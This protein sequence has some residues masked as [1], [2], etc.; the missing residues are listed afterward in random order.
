MAPPLML[1]KLGA[2]MW[3][4]TPGSTLMVPALD[5][6]AEPA[7]LPTVNLWSLSSSVAPLMTP[8][9]ATPW[10]S[11]CATTGALGLVGTEISTVAPESVLPIGVDGTGDQ[12]AD[13]RVSQSPPNL[14]IQLNTLTGILKS[15][16]AKF[17]G[18]TA[19]LPASSV[20]VPLS[21]LKPT[22]FRSVVLSVSTV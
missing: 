14:L 4:S 22:T 13:V 15:A 21:K 16:A 10:S 5:D 17:A 6:V 11:V 1:L 3:N 18:S 12:L 2:L 8:S 20:M 19:A 9:M 7:P